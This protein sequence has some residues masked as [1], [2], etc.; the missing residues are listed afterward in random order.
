MRFYSRIFGDI[1][2]PADA[3]GRLEADAAPVTAGRCVPGRAAGPRR[4]R[5]S[6]GR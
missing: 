5:G 4:G 2:S 3:P 1:P 6:E